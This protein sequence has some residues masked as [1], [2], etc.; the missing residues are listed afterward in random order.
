[1]KGD[2]L[3]LTETTDDKI[4]PKEKPSVAPYYVCRNVIHKYLF[5]NV[6]LHCINDVYPHPRPQHL[7]MPQTLVLMGSNLLL[8][9]LG[10]FW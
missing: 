3:R 1:M 6:Y 5:Y 7:V 10:V 2:F 4:I 9:I 8:S